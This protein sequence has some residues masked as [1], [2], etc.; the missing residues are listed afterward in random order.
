[1]MRLPSRSRRLDLPILHPADTRNPGDRPRLTPG[2]TIERNGRAAGIHTGGVVRV[3]I[4]TRGM[5]V[6]LC[7]LTGA[8]VALPRGQRPGDAAAENPP[9]LRLAE[10]GA[11]RGTWGL[12]PGSKVYCLSHPDLGTGT[13]VEVRRSAHV[14]FGSR[15][16]T[17]DEAEMRHADP[18]R[19]PGDPAAEIAAG[20]PGETFPVGSRINAPKFPLPSRVTC[21]SRPELGNGIVIKTKSVFT[22]QYETGTRIQADDEIRP[23]LAGPGLI[24][25]LPP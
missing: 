1:M 3:S 9:P 16:L 15:V 13:V 6:V 7:V 12:R 14:A 20:S 17:L 4:M 21:P 24:L 22:V 11:R 5:L 23:A 19:P 25:P 18:P 10:P 8:A 2:P